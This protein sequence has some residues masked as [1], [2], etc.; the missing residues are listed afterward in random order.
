MRLR[1]YVLLALV[2]AF[3]SLAVGKDKNK[4]KIVLP[5]D[6]LQAR[7]VMVV[8]S[9]DAGIP[10]NDPRGNRIARMDVE[11]A[12]SKWGRLTP[13]LDVTTADL[14]ISVRKGSG[15]MVTPTISGGPPN[16]PPV[17][18]EPGSEGSVWSTGGHSG[19]P[20]DLTNPG[21]GPQDN[22]P[23][24]SAEIGPTG[25]TFEVYRGRMEYPLDNAP[26]WRYLAKDGL[27]SPDVPAVEAFRKL[28]EEAEKQQK[29]P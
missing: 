3:A 5:G 21:L 1:V 20:P 18:M 9:P 4:K 17:I 12:L 19:R 22:T 8:V 28:I 15:K 16:N 29:G 2:L 25:D 24:P 14:V 10:L 27:R 23:H 11:N 7:T 13:T 6:V 26:V